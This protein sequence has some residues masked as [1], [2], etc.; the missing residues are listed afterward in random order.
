[1]KA[2]ISVVGMDYSDRLSK[3][4]FFRK[5]MNLFTVFST[6]FQACITG[7]CGDGR[8]GGKIC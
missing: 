4:S 7:T 8:T 5:Y 3:S 6:G 1:M 2:R